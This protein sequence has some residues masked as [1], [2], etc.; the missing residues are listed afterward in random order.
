MTPKFEPAGCFGTI[1]TISTIS[2]NTRNTH[3]KH[4]AETQKII[5]G[6]HSSIVV[7]Y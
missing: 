1:S 3:N 2:T 4:T 5:F 7:K 6:D